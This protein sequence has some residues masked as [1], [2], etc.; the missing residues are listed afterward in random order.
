MPTK[1]SLKSLKLRALLISGGFLDPD[2]SNIF[3]S[4]R[5]GGSYMIRD[6]LQKYNIETEVVDMFE[7][8]PDEWAEK[9]LNDYRKPHRVDIVCISATFM[10]NNYVTRLSAKVKKYFPRA[11]ILLGSGNPSLK[12]NHFINYQVYSYGEKAV[13]ACLENYFLGTPLEYKIKGKTKFVNAL[14]NYVAWP[15]EDYSLKYQD[16]DFV[17]SNTV[18]TLEMSRGCRFK[19]SFC[20]WPILGIKEDTS[21]KDIQYQVD[22]LEHNYQ[23]YG[24]TEYFIADDTYN[25]RTSKLEKLAEIVSRLSFEPNFTA[26]MRLDL[27]WSLREQWDLLR[28]AR[29]LSHHYGLETFNKESAKIIG[30][31][32]QAEI[33]KDTLLEIQNYL[34]EDYIGYA[35]LIVGL[36]KESKESIQSTHDWLK[37]NW[38]RGYWH[39]YNLDIQKD[40]E[41]LSAFGTDMAKYNYTIDEGKVPLGLSKKFAD[42]TV[43]WKNEYFDANSSYEFAQQLNANRPK[44]VPN[45]WMTRNGNISPRDVLEK[46]IRKKFDLLYKIM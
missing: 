23:K 28:P 14:H 42:G 38:S 9:Y 33:A 4:N 10:T 35:T 30:K 36:P 40:A 7:S 41:V 29:L 13:I 34:G 37:E 2:H 39:W 12:S 32:K 8:W 15:K 20:N 22:A 16:T 19:C 18:G 44:R 43:F 3:L 6:C 46:Y 26:F 24:M 1:K 11:V 31:G 17:D 45:A 21:Q 27:L 25:D 5:L